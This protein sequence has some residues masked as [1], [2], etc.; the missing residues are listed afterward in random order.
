MQ[1]IFFFAAFVLAVVGCSSKDKIN[2][3]EGGPAPQQPGPIAVAELRA[4]SQLE[5]SQ[6]APLDAKTA[7]SQFQDI[8]TKAFSKDELTRLHGYLAGAKAVDTPALEE[9]LRDYLTKIKPADLSGTANLSLFWAIINNANYSDSLRSLYLNAGIQSSD[10]FFQ[11]GM[12]SAAALQPQL[13]QPGSAL[14]SL[15]KKELALNTPAALTPS[16]QS[17]L[18]LYLQSFAREMKDPGKAP[19]YSDNDHKEIVRLAGLREWLRAYVQFE[20]P[21]IK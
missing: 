3:T 8:K 11:A 18:I 4:M 10:E 21:E 6:K 14:V 2:N 7:C 17:S 5:S 13:D 16:L 12:L 1:R 9:C 15:V 19:H 20:E